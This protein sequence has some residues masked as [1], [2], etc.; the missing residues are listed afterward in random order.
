M[1]REEQSIHKAVVQHLRMRGVS[2]LVWWHTPNGMRY[3]GKSP[4]IQGRIAK[5]LGVRAGVSDLILIHNSRC[6]ALELKSESGR[7][8]E[9]QMQFISDL[10]AAGGFGCIASGLDS[11]LRTLE[12][13]GLLRGEAA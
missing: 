10:N 5:A 13:W 2:N 1:R 7:P 4:V 6:F 9:H 8:T 12:R 11:A 3:G